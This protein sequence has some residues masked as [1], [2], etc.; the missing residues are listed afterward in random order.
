MPETEGLPELWQLL[1]GNMDDAVVQADS[2]RLIEVLDQRAQG[3]NWPDAVAGDMERHYSPGRTW[4]A[5]A[6]ALVV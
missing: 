5:T 4:E 3:R 6:R 1:K 2:N